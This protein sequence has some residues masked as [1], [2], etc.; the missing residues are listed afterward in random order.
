MSITLSPTRDKTYFIPARGYRKYDRDI[1]INAS[2]GKK[3][4]IDKIYTRH[5]IDT[6]KAVGFDTAR[7]EEIMKEFAINMPNAI[8][9]LEAE[10]PSDSPKSISDSIFSNTLI[11][12]NKIH[13]NKDI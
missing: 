4:P 1:G 7:M 3:Y 8:K 5:F 11:T 2:K 12:L 9:E 10:L 13:F 6:A